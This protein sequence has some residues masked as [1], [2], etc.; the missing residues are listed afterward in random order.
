[1]ASNEPRGTAAM[2]VNARGEYLLHLRDNIEGICDPGMWSFLGGSRD[3]D[4]ERAEEAIARE[5]KEEAGLVVPGLE[6]YDVVTLIGPDGKRGQ[7]TVFL[8]HWD[9]EPHL[10][11]LTEGV[12]LHWF[13]AA[14]TSRLV[15]APWARDLIEQHEAGQTA[16]IK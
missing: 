12:M 11:P 5:L 1:M 3:T 13:P 4:E 14:T 2:I 16:D 7:A 10:L 15:M 8:G 6:R 9:G